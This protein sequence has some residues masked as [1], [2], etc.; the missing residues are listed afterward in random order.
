MCISAETLRDYEDKAASAMDVD[1]AG[2]GEG[3]EQQQNNSNAASVAALADRLGAL[4]GLSRAAGETDQGE[5]INCSE[6]F[7]YSCLMTSH[8]NIMLCEQIYCAVA[9]ALCGCC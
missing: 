8:C 2:G 4:L 5:S 6:A 3:E 7:L 9:S 1:V